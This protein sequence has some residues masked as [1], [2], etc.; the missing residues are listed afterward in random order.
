MLGD[1]YRRGVPQNILHGIAYES[2]V[3]GSIKRVKNVVLAD[4]VHEP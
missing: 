1:K 2:E 3:P 4:A